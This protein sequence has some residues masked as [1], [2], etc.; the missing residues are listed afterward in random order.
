MF[1]FRSLIAIK[2]KW[3]DAAVEAVVKL[4]TGERSGGIDK[5]ISIL[6]KRRGALHPSFKTALSKLYAYTGDEGGIRHPILEESTV[7][8]AEAK[9]MLVGC[10]AFVNFLIDSSR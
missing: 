5:A 6:E 1:I 9:F 2:I 7:D 8:F 4:L 3:K 10:S